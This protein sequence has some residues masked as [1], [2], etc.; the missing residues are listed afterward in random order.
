MSHPNAGQ[1]MSP[2]L[3]AAYEAP[4]L[5]AGSSRVRHGFFGRAGG[6][7]TGVYHS[8]NTGLGSRDDAAA[9]G[10]NRS[11]V[12]GAMGLS[13][14]DRLVTVHQVHSPDVVT[15]TGPIALAQRPHADA[16][17]TATPGLGLGVL[18]ADCAPVLF[19]DAERG[20]IGAAHAGWKGALYG[21]LDA[22]VA[23][24]VTLGADRQAIV[25]AVGPTIGQNAYEVGPEYVARFIEMDAQNAQ[26]FAA[27]VGDRSLF[28]LP[29][30]VAMRLAMAG[31]GTVDLI[32]A[33]TCTEEDALFS[34]RRSVLRQEDDYG[35]NI[36]VIAL[37]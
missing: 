33:C 37:V 17:V 11:R 27:G 12:A 23:A 32:P 29:G 15:V 18:T 10:E 30:Y 24:M 13:H 21:V 1:T 2:H 19:A 28:D 5:S 4:V 31:V 25:A 22:T 34:Y 20:V 14:V 36:A 26:F 8:L 35:R 16:M 3:P 6:V 7:S 9:V